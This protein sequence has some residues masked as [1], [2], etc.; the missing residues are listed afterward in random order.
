MAD[1]NYFMHASQDGRSPWERAQAQGISA[2]AEN[3]A[4]GSSSAQGVLDQWRG[5]NGHCKNMMNQIQK[6]FAVGYGSHSGSTYGHYWTQM[7]AS[8]EQQEDRSCY[9]NGALFDVEPPW[10]DAEDFLHH[11]EPDMEVEEHAATEDATSH[12]QGGIQS[13]DSESEGQFGS[14]QGDAEDKVVG[15]A[16]ERG[17][18]GEDKH[19]K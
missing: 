13:G 1:N 10:P 9:P 19:V 17:E 16:I 6:L 7:F 14:H 11:G 8:Q 5:S 2:S 18:D 4:A 15:L 12:E 3:I